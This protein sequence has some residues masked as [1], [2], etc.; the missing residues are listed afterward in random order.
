MAT[1]S[2]AGEPSGIRHRGGDAHRL[3]T[4]VD[5]AFAFALTL[6]VISFDAV[7]SSYGELMTALRGIPAFIASFAIIVMLWSAHHVWSRR[8]GLSDVPTLLISLA[9]VM[10]VMIYVYPLRSLMSVTL[11]QLTNGWAPGEFDLTSAAEAR[12]LFT[13]YGAGFSTAT[14]C[15]VALY[16]HALRRAGR[17]GLTAYECA[18]TRLEVVVWSLVSGVGALSV[19]LAQ[20]LP[21]RLLGLAGWVYS[22]LAVLSPACGTI[23]G[24]RAERL[25]D[26]SGESAA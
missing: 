18:L 22:S 12:G 21:D 6:L 16:L 26:R 17:L 14:A 10:I 24:I 8:Y 3:E 5:A 1:T 9:L 7:P 11:H 4:F 23:L 25:R 13:I 20:T 19:V 15:I 2:A